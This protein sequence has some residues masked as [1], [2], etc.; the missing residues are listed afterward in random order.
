MAHSVHPI[1]PLRRVEPLTKFSERGGGLDRTSIFREG[2]TGKNGK[3][4]MT[5]SRGLQKFY[6]QEKG[7]MGLRMKNLNIL[8]DQ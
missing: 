1:F 2:I 3:E 6:K 4:G 8:G 5:F 7:E